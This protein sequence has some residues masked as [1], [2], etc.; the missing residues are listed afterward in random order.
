MD[1]N[2]ALEAL[3][4]EANEDK[5]TLD[6]IIAELAGQTVSPVGMTETASYSVATGLW[7]LTQ[8]TPNAQGVYEG[9]YG[10]PSATAC[11]VI[12]EITVVSHHAFV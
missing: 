8:A 4:L 5:T 12:K 3:L 2:A 7:T 9:E 1:M 10:L 6:T 11:S